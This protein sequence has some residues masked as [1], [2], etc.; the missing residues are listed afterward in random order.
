MKLEQCY[1]LLQLV[2]GSS[3]TE[4]KNAYRRLARLMHPDLHPTDQG[5]Q[6]RF[7]MLHQAYQILQ[8]SIEAGCSE[9]DFPTPNCLLNNGVTT[10]SSPFSATSPQEIQLKWN[11]YYQL[12]NLLQNR[13]LNLAVAVIDGLAQ[14][15]R[16]DPHIQQWQGIIYYFIG[17]HL[18]DIGQISKAKIYLQKAQKADPQN[19][20]LS[21]QIKWEYQRI[22]RIMT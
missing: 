3:L 11:T 13:Q 18:L 8:D 19:V 15:H 17:Q 12:Q 1:P 21:Q 22:A 4:I 7:V 2:P 20:Q 14:R 10:I 5:A 6:Q 9:S 16:Q